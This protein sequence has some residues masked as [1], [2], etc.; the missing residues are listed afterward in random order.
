MSKFADRIASLRALMRAR[1][2]DAVV[3]TGSDPHGSEYPAER[4]KQVRWLTGFTGEAADLVVTHDH[5]GLWTDTRYFIQAAEQLAGT[6]VELHKT[7]VPEEVLIPEWLAARFADAQE[8]VIAVD[9]ASI[10]DSFVDEISEALAG[11]GVQPVIVSSPDFI[12]YLWTDRPAIPQTPVFTIDSGSDRGTKISQLR[13]FCAS[14]GCD[15]ILLSAL[16]EI[17]WTLDVRGSDIEFN[18]Y[19]ISYLLITEEDVRWFVLKD[20]IEDPDTERTFEIL[21]DEGIQFRVRRDGLFRGQKGPEPA[22]CRGD[23]VRRRR[24]PLRTHSRG[25]VEGREEPLRD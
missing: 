6:G 17:A 25:P 19:V 12:N 22:A 5:A 9:G 2:W 16:D 4:Y 13:D 14:R 24:R 15:G 18:P 11:A 7:R 8:P 10:M 3:L 23:Q 1:D 21:A 20:E